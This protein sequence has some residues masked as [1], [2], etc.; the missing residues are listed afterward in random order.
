M[1]SRDEIEIYLEG[2]VTY[3]EHASKVAEMCLEVLLDI[4]EMLL[5]IANPIYYKPDAGIPRTKSGP[6]QA[7]RSSDVGK[8][9]HRSQ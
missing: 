5:P 1:K 4:R 6:N 9:R 2:W 8:R 3:P 7:G